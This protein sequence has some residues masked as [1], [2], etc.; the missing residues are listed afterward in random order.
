[1]KY[2]KSIPIDYNVAINKM[3]KKLKAMEGIEN[4]KLNN[5]ELII[6]SNIILTDDMINDYLVND[7]KNVKEDIFY[8]DYIDCPNCASKVEIA[9]NKSKLIKE[10]QVIFLSKKIIIKHNEVDV[11]PEVCRI[12]KSI[13]KDTNVYKEEK[14]NSLEKI[15]KKSGVFSKKQIFILGTIFFII[16]TIINVLGN[17]E[18]LSLFNLTPILKG[19]YYLIPLFT[20][21]IISY[22]LLAYD[23]I[24]KSIYGILHKDYFNESL[25]MVI[26][27]LGAIILS[28]IGEIELLEACAVVLLYKI[29]ESLQDRATEKSKN[30]IK[31]LVTLDVENVT[32]KDGNIISINEAKIKDIIIVK[33]G[34]KI[35]LDGKIVRGNTTLDMKILTGESEPIFVDV[36]EEVLSGAINLTNVVEIEVIRE[37]S[38]STLS[39]VKK[40]VEEASEK[41]AKSEE[42]I[43][44]FSRVY[45]PIILLLAVIVLFVQLIL[46][47]NIQES[48][49][50]VFAFLVISCPCSLVISV[51]LAYFASIGKGS[52]EGILIKGGNYLESLSNIETVVFDK[53]GTITEGDFEIIEINS[54]VSKDELIEILC[55][56]ESYSN[57][58]IA[59][60][61]VSTYGYVNTDENVLVEE[62]AGL[63]IKY[64]S[65]NNI[66]LVGNDKI[67][68]KF[69]IDY[70]NCD[71]I[72]THIY[73]S[74]NNQYIGN[75]VIRDKI[76]EN[77]KKVVSSLKENKIES[78]MLT[79]DKKVF[80]EFI[81][82]E[83]GISKVKSEL[84]PQDK[85]QYVDSLV[86][87]KKKNIVYVGDGINDAPSLRRA[88]VGIALGGIG[89]DLAKEAADIVIMNDDIN[90]V[91][92]VI[93]LSIFTKK[94]II[95]NI[96]F[97]LFTKI[98]A[99]IISLTGIL[100][101]YA[102]LVA[103][104][105]DV[106]V[107]LLCILNSLRI[108][109][110]R[111]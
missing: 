55:K 107:C 50:N 11:F 83:V 74:K 78:I 37:N 109:K 108:I 76:K 21:Y 102:M 31:S 20:F 95:Q 53:T 39:K 5:D 110:S 51:P 34:D 25:L 64:E 61:I 73:I 101:S 24:Y 71:T 36:G 94:I 16:A 93:D 88:D 12:V 32:L 28:F 85:Y 27:S 87:N 82:I 69:S 68:N 67:M 44:K 98:L 43:T 75:V 35:P 86:I 26:A 99:M 59:K 89:V 65:D 106:G 100:D 29:G 30:A 4:V 72:G 60:F 96:V 63:G 56:A 33:A 40:I 52:K 17:E 57:H 6:E 111:K 54:N 42:F 66:Y 103:I 18:I 47:K 9:L 49:N 22:I 45:T 13:E 104:F 14:S 10:A 80:G 81:A 2:I 19:N 15:D 58:P 1:M 77:S 23:L 48:F 90:K 3:I 41:K 38:Q 7:E 46:E 70:H 8:F 105:A 97:I 92:K 79:G 84:L 91:K 62:I